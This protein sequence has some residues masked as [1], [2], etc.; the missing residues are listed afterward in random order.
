MGG[1]QVLGMMTFLS[2]AQLKVC[3]SVR[4][5]TRTSDMSHHIKILKSV[6]TMDIILLQLGIYCRR[7]LYFMAALQLNLS[8]LLN[9]V[10]SSY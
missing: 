7:T 5:C 8:L 1:T 9:E 4:S 6:L 10:M 2:D 3:T